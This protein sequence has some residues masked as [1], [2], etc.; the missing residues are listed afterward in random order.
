MANYRKRKSELMDTNEAVDSIERADVVRIDI[1]SLNGKNFDHKFTSKDVKSLWSYLKHDP[2]QVVGQ[3]SSKISSKVL[4]VNIELNRAFS[5]EEVSPTPD[6]QYEV[7]TPF[8]N[9]TYD[10]KVVGIGRIQ[11]TNP[12][13]KVQVTLRRVHFRFK[14][15]QADSW[16]SKFGKIVIPSRFDSFL[17][18]YS[19][20][21]A[22]DPRLRIIVHK[23]V[24]RNKLFP[25]AVSW[26]EFSSVADLPIFWLGDQSRLALIAVSFE[27]TTVCVYEPTVKQLLVVTNPGFFFV[28]TDEIKNFTLSFSN[29]KDSENLNTEAIS[30]TIE[31]TEHIPEWLPMYGC[32]VRIYYHGMKTQCNSCWQLGHFSQK[33]TNKKLSWK[34]FIN[35]LAESG[36]FEKDLFGRWLDPAPTSNLTPAEELQK[37]M[38]GN[39]DLRKAITLLKAASSTTKAAGGT[40]KPIP[41]GR[42]QIKGAKKPKKDV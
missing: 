42:F 21:Y 20:L 9:Y 24:S 29:I 41:K 39:E 8:G 23:A 32:R 11:E 25:I 5:I 14:A 22:C 1:L 27:P 37:L 4:R 34:E 28:N 12:G 35:H 38:E 26:E 30:A 31:L 15:E 13:D 2:N 10:C 36:K 19:H 3:S 7:V 40:S 6:F 17:S 16:L 33:C 18:L